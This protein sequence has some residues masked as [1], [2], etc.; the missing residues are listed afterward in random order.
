MRAIL[1]TIHGKHIFRISFNVLK[2]NLI[3]ETTLFAKIN[4]WKTKFG[5]KVCIDI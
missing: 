4:E 2:S 1:G 3:A 5:K